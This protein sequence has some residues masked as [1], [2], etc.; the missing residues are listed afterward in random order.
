M[1]VVVDSHCVYTVV[2]WREL[3]ELEN[4]FILFAIFVLKII[5]KFVEIWQSFDKKNNLHSFLTS[6]CLV[7]R[8]NAT[9]I[10]IGNVKYLFLCGVLFGTELNS[11]LCL[12]FLFASN[13]DNEPESPKED[14][15]P[16]NVA[17]TV[18]RDL[19]CRASYGNINAVIR[20]VLV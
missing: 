12:L 4:N 10:A 11:D 13:F 20:P 14:D 19:I 17:E 6:D 2:R 8:H 15:N 16:A 3:G 18:F 7:E 5:S 1:A 9:S